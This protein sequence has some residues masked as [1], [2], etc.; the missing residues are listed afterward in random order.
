MGILTDKVHVNHYSNVSQIPSIAS[1]HEHNRA[2][3]VF[4]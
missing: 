3:H 4:M 1:T 2:K